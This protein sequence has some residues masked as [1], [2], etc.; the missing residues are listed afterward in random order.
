MVGAAFALLF[1]FIA[2][3]IG[4]SIAKIGNRTVDYQILEMSK[5]IEREISEAI[6]ES[7]SFQSDRSPTLAASSDFLQKIGERGASISKNIEWLERCHF[8]SQ[9]AKLPCEFSKEEI[10]K[11]RAIADKWLDFQNTVPSPAGDASS[12]QIA[13]AIAKHYIGNGPRLL[14]EVELLSA[15]LGAGMANRFSD[16]LF[17]AKIAIAISGLLASIL[18]SL[19]YHRIAAPLRRA[20]DSLRLASNAPIG[21][22]IAGGRSDEIGDI[23]TSFNRLTRRADSVFRMSSRIQQANGPAQVAHV[24]HEELR[25]SIPLDALALFSLSASTGKFV[26]E[27]AEGKAPF[28]RVFSIPTDDSWISSAFAKKQAT[29]LS[30]EMKSPFEKVFRAAGLSSAVAIPLQSDGYGPAL[31]ICAATPAN[32]YSSS[33]RMAFLSNLSIQIAGA[34]ERAELPELLAVSCLI[35]VASLAESRDPYAAG[36]LERVSLYSKA[37]SE[38]L[39]SD[40]AFRE[41]MSPSYIQQV[42]SCSKLHDIGN[43]SIPE[44]IF[45]KNAPLDEREIGMMRMHPVIGAETLRRCSHAGET[46]GHPALFSLAIDIAESHHEKYDGSGYPNGLVGDSI[47]LPAR[48]VAIADAFDALTTRRAHKSAWSARQAAEHIQAESGKSFD[49]RIVAAFIRAIPKI[50]A[51]RDARG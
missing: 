48:I 45:R 8:S 29:P 17:F 39:A 27:G 38:A 15:A 36:H 3:A 26:L 47:P 34:L 49:P 30:R 7:R 31:L 37:I 5:D 41:R 32:A 23:V 12:T 20:M 51:I 42:E 21:R 4:T 25:H 50:E 46:L 43:I 10:A 11:T 33:A 9:S 44:N 22:P 2:G 28:P 1:V 18:I 16:A 35:G 14:G 19:L 40:P 13:L 24:L 6:G